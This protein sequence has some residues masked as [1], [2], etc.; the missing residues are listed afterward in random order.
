MRSDMS[1]SDVVAHSLLCVVHSLGASQRRLRKYRA[2]A[3]P[4]RLGFESMFR[5]SVQQRCVCVSCHTGDDDAGGGMGGGMGGGIYGQHMP[6]MRFPKHSNAYML[7]Y[8]RLSDWDRI[9]CDVSKVRCEACYA[10]VRW[11]QPA[12]RSTQAELG[13]QSWLENHVR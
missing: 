13:L 12:H 7:V 5:H 11:K 1:E 8:V 3:S 9:M 6:H 2:R 4:P 10:F